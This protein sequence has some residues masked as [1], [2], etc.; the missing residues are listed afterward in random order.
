MQRLHN[1]GLPHC[2][3]ETSHTNCEVVMQYPCLNGMPQAHGL[4]AASNSGQTCSERMLTDRIHI[5]DCIGDGRGKHVHCTKY[6]DLQIGWSCAKRGLSMEY[7][8]CSQC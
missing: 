8:P 1:I 3:R 2:K 4:P 5:V 7:W 6:T